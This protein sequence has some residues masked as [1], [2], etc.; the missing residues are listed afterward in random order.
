MQKQGQKTV[1][2]QRGGYRSCC[3]CVT[4]H[5]QPPVLHTINRALHACQQQHQDGQ[6][7]ECSPRPQI[8]FVGFCVNFANG[9]ALH[10]NTQFD[11]PFHTF[12]HPF[13]QLT[14]LH[15][16]VRQLTALPEAIA[17]R[18]Q[19]YNRMCSQRSQKLTCDSCQH[20]TP[21]K[22]GCFV[23]SQSMPSYDVKVGLNYAHS[24]HC[25]PA[26]G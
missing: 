10:L 15:L 14:G 2:K 18:Q 9:P 23:T 16:F 17:L 6:N 4:P 13:V 3:I 26:P 11:S 22:F 25:A 8:N 24:A 21:L 19:A 12:S 7:V 5:R 20:K 1:C